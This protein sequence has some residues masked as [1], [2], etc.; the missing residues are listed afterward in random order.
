MHAESGQN[1]A[2]PVPRFELHNGFRETGAELP[3]DVQLGDFPVVALHHEAITGV[4]RGPVGAARRFQ[5]RQQFGRV[6]QRGRVAFIRVEEYVTES[7][8]AALAVEC[9]II[10]KMFFLITLLQIQYY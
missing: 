1:G 6:G 8:Q 4:K 3:P 10:L 7:N 5:L 2:V 9:L